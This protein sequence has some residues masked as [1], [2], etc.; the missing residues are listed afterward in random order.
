MR[1]LCGML[2]AVLLVTAGMEG[3]CGQIAAP[4][5]AAPLVIGQTFTLEFK[6]LGETRRINA[7]LP[8]AYTDSATLRLP[9]PYMPGGGIDEDFLHV[10]G[11]FRCS[12][13]T[14]SCGRSSWLA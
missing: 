13:A 14:A 4:A 10:T 7:Y 12:R 3:A 8:P 6:A 5:A 2:S 9:M 1:Y 11:S